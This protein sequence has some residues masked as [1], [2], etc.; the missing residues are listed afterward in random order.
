MMKRYGLVNGTWGDVICGLGYFQREFP[1]GGNIIYYGSVKYISEFLSAQSFIH[2]LVCIEPRTYEDYSETLQL[3]WHPEH[4]D[5]GVARVLAGSRITKD[6]VVN[7]TVKFDF[8]RE[9]ETENLPVA[10]H[11]QI[12][13]HASDWAADFARNLGRPFYILQP[14]SINTV[15]ERSHYPYWRDVIEWIVRDK[16]K[17]FVIVGRGWPASIYEGFENVTNLVDKAPTMSHVFGLSNHSAGVITTSN[18][19][20]HWCV[21][22]SISTACIAT[23]RSSEPTHFFHRILKGDHITVFGYYNKV[24]PILFHLRERWSIWPT[25]ADTRY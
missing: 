19:L 20:A 22:Q 9:Y 2:D 15:G 24:M 12:P 13:D 8:A 10:S 18:S 16:S 7:T 1:E 23:M 17:H 25:N 4:V 5:E 3:L 21:S 14:Y 6:Q 11:L